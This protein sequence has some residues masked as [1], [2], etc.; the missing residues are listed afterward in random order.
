MLKVPSGPLV[1]PRK[2]MMN[3]WAQ[4]AG[5]PLPWP[6]GLDLAFRYQYV[7]RHRETWRQKSPASAEVVE[8]WGPMAA[9]AEMAEMAWHCSM[10]ATTSPSN[11][12]DSELDGLHCFTNQFNQP[13][14]DYG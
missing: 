3:I 1:V 10:V 5:F 6:Q 2:F 7:Y 14:H 4:A 8:A 12:I 11:T 9:T 13:F